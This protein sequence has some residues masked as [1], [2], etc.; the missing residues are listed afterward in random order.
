MDIYF[1]YKNSDKILLYVL[2]TEKPTINDIV[3]FLTNEKNP[4]RVQDFFTVDVKCPRCKKVHKN[5]KIAKYPNITGEETSI[6]VTLNKRKMCNNVVNGKLCSRRLFSRG[7]GRPKPGIDKEDF[8]IIYEQKGKDFSYL[9]PL[10]LKNIIELHGE[11]YYDFEDY[12]IRNMIIQNIQRREINELLKEKYLIKKE[13]CFLPNF[14]KIF[15]IFITKIVDNLRETEQE[16]KL[17]CPYNNF[18]EAWM[19]NSEIKKLTKLLAKDLTSIKWLFLS[20]IDLYNYEFDSLNQLLDEFAKAMKRIEVDQLER[21]IKSRRLT[22]KEKRIILELAFL[23]KRYYLNQMNN[24][25]LG[26]FAACLK[27]KNLSDLSSPEVPMSFLKLY[28][29]EG[30][31]KCWYF[32]YEFRE[33]EE[34][35]EKRDLIESQR[36]EVLTK[37]KYT[38]KIKKR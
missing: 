27:L 1:K 10:E 20:F 6:K 35:W 15:E 16:R 13:G 21:I 18:H 30:K 24:P 38:R 14:Q 29:R 17:E 4:E 26:A 31:G 5:V 11:P 22:K 25:L 19:P 33:D 3:L 7:R 23:C 37:F 2:E 28:V 34:A 32:P 36:K 8:S 9:V 12:K